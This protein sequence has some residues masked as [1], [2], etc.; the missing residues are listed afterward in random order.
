MWGDLLDM[1]DPLE[2]LA[3]TLDDAIASSDAEGALR[4][5]VAFVQSVN[6]DPT[7]A[8]HVFGS[9]RL[10]ALLERAA[11]TLP[12]VEGAVADAGDAT[13]LYV[14]TEIYLTGGHTR[15]L[16]DY[17]AAQPGRPHQVLLTNLHARPPCPETLKRFEAVGASVEWPDEPGL[18]HAAQWVAAHLARHPPARVFMFVHHED[19]AAWA[20]CLRARPEQLYLCHHADH[21]LALGLYLPGVRSIELTSFSFHHSRDV[22]GLA[23]PIHIPLI[24][25]EIAARPAG[26]FTASPGEAAFVTCSSGNPG[27]FRG[28]YRHTYPNIIT[29]RLARFGGRHVHIGG[30]DEVGMAELISACSK[31]RVDPAR[32]ERVG[33]VPDLG[34][35]MGL[36]RVSVYLSSFPIVGGRAAIEVMASGTPIIGHHHHWSEFLGGECLLPTEAPAW[37]SPADLW[38]ILGAMTPARQVQLGLI[39]RRHWEQNHR[40][41]IL[42]RC[43]A[44]EVSGIPARPRNRAAI[45]D[46][47]DDFFARRGHGPGFA[48]QLNATDR[49]L[50]LE[51]KLARAQAALEKSREEVQRLR[52]ARNKPAPGW[53]ERVF[54]PL[55]K[56]ENSVRKRLP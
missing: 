43:L 56:L 3:A 26:D 4:Q 37:R 21:H 48:T 39:G 40:P 55:A 23:N 12:P 1:P 24:S 10:D 31:L 38:E 53:I 25:R 19:A 49:V 34:A 52:R 20:G 6:A 47:L 54:R 17:I 14:A 8:G 11:S 7:A 29:E 44:G 46:A 33:H 18:V 22:L 32:F 16:E 36:N 30:L 5:I 51:Q 2:T 13:Q 27:K 35:A 15:V 42:N 50:V 28:D 45:P 41:E 9:R